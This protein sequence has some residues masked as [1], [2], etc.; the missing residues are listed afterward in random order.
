MEDDML[1]LKVFFGLQILAII[2]RMADCIKDHPRTETVNIGT[3]I[4]RLIIGI[5]FAVWIGITLW[6]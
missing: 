1:I 6:G 4:V 3:D 2:L 5:G